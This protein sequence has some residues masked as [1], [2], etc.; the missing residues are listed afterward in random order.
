MHPRKHGGKPFKGLTRSLA[1]VSVVL[2]LALIAFSLNWILTPSTVPLAGLPNFRLL[3]S[4]EENNIAD[5]SKLEITISSIGLLDANSLDDWNA[6]EMKPNVVVDLTRLPGLNAQ[7]VWSGRLP[8]GHYA[9]MFIDVKKII[10]ELKTDGG[11]TSMVS[12]PGGRFRISKPFI[13]T[14]NGPTVNYVYDLIAVKIGQDSQYML[15]TQVEY[16]GANQVFHEVGEGD[17]VIRVVDGLILPGETVLLAITTEGVPVAEAKITFNGDKIGVTDGEGYISFEVPYYSVL[18][19]EAFKGEL[20]GELRIELE[21]GHSLTIEVVDGLVVPGEKIALLVSL[22]GNPV[23]EAKIIVN[24]DKI[25]YTDREGY[26]YFMIPHYP[27]LEIKAIKGEFHGVL[28]FEF[29]E[30]YNLAIEVVEGTVMPGEVVVLLVSLGEEPV[31][32]AKMKVNGDIIGYTNSE[33]LIS[34]EV[35]YYSVLE[36]EAF[37]GELYG[38]LRIEL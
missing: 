19:I 4:D 16:S 28:N 36:I 10:G 11:K 23:P 32:E 20:Y 6:I 29:E 9:S 37:K 2:A 12:L 1:T 13:I 18:E 38:E 26:I 21:G 33:G 34:F 8:E 17:L 24:G 27:V 31:H 14:E 35:P 7:N 3:I 30:D 22:E 25:G 15:Q 5:F